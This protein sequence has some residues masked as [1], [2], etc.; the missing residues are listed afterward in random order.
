MAW[1]FGP[2]TIDQGDDLK[3]RLGEEF[4]GRDD[5]D[6]GRLDSAQRKQLATVAKIAKSMVDSKQAG[7]GPW[8]VS[9]ASHAPVADS[10]SRPYLSISVVGSPPSA[11]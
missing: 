8:E 4:D 11:E 3:A 7:P 2:V 1:S 9:A 6:E 5:A 10:G